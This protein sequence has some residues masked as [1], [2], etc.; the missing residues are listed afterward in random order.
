MNDTAAGEACVAAAKTEL[1][2]AMRL[3]RRSL[4]DTDMRSDAIVALLD[5]L[6]VV[7]AARHVMAFTAIP[8]EP[9]LAAF[10][11]VCTD[12]GQE[13]MTPEAIPDPAWPD[14]VVVPGIAFTRTGDRLGQGGGWY[15][16]FLAGV[17]EQCTTIGVGFEPQ[18]VADLPLDAHDVSVDAIVTEEGVWWST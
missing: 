10:V 9:D 18:I 12:R 6:T 16:R 15:D 1:R 8:G 4:A 5:R 7:A 17:G 11:A 2:H 3:S 14:V 13:V